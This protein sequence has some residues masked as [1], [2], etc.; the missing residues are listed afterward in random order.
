[1]SIKQNFP[2][3]DPTLNLDF[4]NSRT[5]DSRITFTRASA[6]T[7]TNAQG[8]LQTVRDNKPRIDYDPVTGECKGLLIEEQRTNVSPD[9][10]NYSG[11]SY[12]N[13]YGI[14]NSTLAP[15]GTNS[16]LLIQNFVN[17]SSV[18]CAFISVLT[19]V[20]AGQV[21]TCSIY[22]KA[23]TNPD[24][25]IWAIYDVPTSV[26]YGN[27]NIFWSN[28]VPT[29]TNGATV[30]S[31]G[32]GW[33]RI[34]LIA[35]VPSGQT[36]MVAL[37]YPSSGSGSKNVYCW[38][39]QFELGTFATSFIPTTP[40]FTSRASSAT[41]FDATGIL[42]TAPKNNA[43]YGY[44][45][46]YKQVD[47]YAGNNLTVSGN[48]QIV[49]GTSGSLKPQ[50]LILEAAATN[51]AT[52]SYNL[53]TA[54]TGYYFT[55]A[56][57]FAVTGETTAPDNTYTASKFVFTGANDRVDQGYGTAPSTGWY[58]LSVWLKGAAGTVVQ[59]S[60]LTST[61]GNV[62]P[63]VYLNGQWQRFSVRKYFNSGETIRVHAPIIRSTMG[64]SVTAATGE[65]GVYATYVYLW[66]IQIEAGST[67]TS[68]IPTYGATATR[69][70]DALNSP[71]IT[72]AVDVAVIKPAEFTKLNSSLAATLYGEASIISGTAGNTGVPALVA[73]SNSADSGT[74]RF[75]LRRTT[76]TSDAGYAGF[77]YRLATVI[78]G[79]SYSIDYSAAEGA[80]P[81]WEDSAVHKTIFGIDTTSQ[82]AYG[83]G[84]SAGITSI[85]IPNFDKFD[86]VEI[87]NGGSSN[88][89][90]GHIRKIAYYNKRLSNTQLQALTV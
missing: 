31:V 24:T 12:L 33:Y 44:E 13:C 65:T 73:L 37:L 9:I 45:M 86:Q 54:N 40:A 16:G 50:G 10:S 76:M 8:V 2:T 11:I 47:F 18:T 7:A 55:G 71:A 26:G 49:A 56:G 69:A 3:I 1:M 81:E 14:P 48:N 88:T 68:Y 74:H 43:R 79:T 62:E 63:A 83:D 38:A 53:S 72:R 46:P 21:Y 42:R 89:W 5:V 80:Q 23:G 70:A 64:N 25:T 60:L 30:T 39:P 90:N 35:T 20:S 57:S 82:Q 6:A 15:D 19:A 34:S 75:I 41:Y 51:L 36:N 22:L 85:A 4:A 61:G 87:G 67:A 84:A 27:T 66:G 29:A 77:N 52:Y 32:N 78:N 59:V 17:P 28:G 58:T